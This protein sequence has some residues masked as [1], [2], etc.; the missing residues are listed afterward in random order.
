MTRNAFSIFVLYTVSQQVLDLDCV[1]FHFGCPI[2][3]PILLG[4]M[5]HMLNGQS[6]KAR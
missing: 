4:L 5:R 6:S 3:N 2:V 1:D